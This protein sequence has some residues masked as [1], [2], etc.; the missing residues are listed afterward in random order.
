[1]TVRQ[2]KVIY[3][4]VRPDREE[5]ITPTNVIYHTPKNSGDDE[6]ILNSNSKLE[7]LVSDVS[8]EIESESG[9]DITS[10]PRSRKITET[11][12]LQESVVGEYY[13]ESSSDESV[14][15]EGPAQILR[16]KK[17][18][19]FFFFYV[20]N[21]QSY[22]VDSNLKNF[23]SIAAFLIAKRLPNLYKCKYYFYYISYWFSFIQLVY[24]TFWLLDGMYE[25]RNSGILE[26][27]FETACFLT[28]SVYK[29]CLWKFILSDDRL[30]DARDFYIVYYTSAAVA[31]HSGSFIMM[32][33]SVLYFYVSGLVA[34]VMQLIAKS[35]LTELVTVKEEKRCMKESYNWKQVKGMIRSQKNVIITMILMSVFPNLVSKLYSHNVSISPT[36]ASHWAT[37]SNTEFGAKYTGYV[38][39]VLSLKILRDTKAKDLLFVTNSI[40]TYLALPLC[41]LIYATENHIY[42][43]LSERYDLFIST[44]GICFIEF[45]RGF[46]TML[47]LSNAIE[48]AQSNQN[49]SIIQLL[50]L[51]GINSFTDYCLSE[52]LTF[53]YTNVQYSLSSVL[54]IG[55]TCQ[56]CSTR[57]LNKI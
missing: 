3:H 30:E 45:Y 10:L 11:H 29:V 39:A 12:V 28:A 24:A 55:L 1:M 5:E 46:Q 43:I 35:F 8:T 50:F 14:H 23:D 42:H 32:K 57:F 7:S 51:F 18:L 56:S 17:L 44:V 52:I 27:V 33:S 9:E 15:Y 21:F 20:I 2:R 34:N 40:F 19:F 54:L 31:Y 36:M 25:F 6:I 37:V 49:N 13:E 47:L 22:A 53:M 26:Y 16:C 48:S 41:Y 38:T 4:K